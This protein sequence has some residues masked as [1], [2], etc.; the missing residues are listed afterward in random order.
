MRDL[1]E[2]FTEARFGKQAAEPVEPKT[3]ASITGVKAYLTVPQINEK[4]RAIRNA[5]EESARREQRLRA[6]A[7]QLADYA[8]HKLESPYGSFWGGVGDIIRAVVPGFSPAASIKPMEKDA[9]VTTYTTEEEESPYITAQMLAGL[10]G[11]GLA[12][13]KHRGLLSEEGGRRALENLRAAATG[14]GVEMK[15]APAI[16]SQADVVKA[17]DRLR[18]ANAA[19]KKIKKGLATASVGEVA[20]ANLDSAVAD[21]IKARAELTAKTK[22]YKATSAMAQAGTLKG[23]F[24]QLFAK[25]PPTAAQRA[26]TTGATERRKLL[27]QAKSKARLGGGRAAVVGALAATAPFMLRRWWISRKTRAK[28]GTAGLEAAQQAAS[29]IE[30]ARKLQ[31]WRQRQMAELEKAVGPGAAKWQPPV[32]PASPEAQPTSV[33][34]PGPYAKYELLPYNPAPPA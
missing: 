29:D 6:R 11:A 13:A 4:T 28:G 18:A 31:E 10:T 1:I 12:A 8:K 16:A 27:S 19:V 33:N 3:P 2:V 7:E 32:T 20:K 17:R 5:I 9:G 24:K 22:A 15:G 30:A 34:V 14:A 21:A 23:K 26:A 25:K